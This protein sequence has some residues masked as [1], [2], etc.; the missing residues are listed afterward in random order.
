MLQDALDLLVYQ[1][2]Y[3]VLA[4]LLIHALDPLDD[5]PLRRRIGSLLQRQRPVLEQKQRTVC[6]QLSLERSVINAP[7]LPPPQRAPRPSEPPQH[8]SPRCH[9]RPWSGV[10]LHKQG[11]AP[12]ANSIGALATQLSLKATFC[13]STGALRSSARWACCRCECSSRQLARRLLNSSLK[14]TILPQ[15]R[16]AALVCALG[17]L[18][19]CCAAVRLCSGGGRHRIMDDSLRSL[20]AQMEA[21]VILHVDMDAFYCQVEQRLR[22]EL[23]GRPLAVMQYNPQN[24]TELAIEDDRRMDESDGSL[25]AVSYE[26]RAAGVKRQMRGQEARKACPELALVQVPCAH[27]KSDIS[28]YREAGAE[29]VTV[30]SRFAT[31]TERASIDEVYVDITAAALREL[32]APEP[33]RDDA[34]ALEK[35]WV[36]G[37]DDRHEMDT[38]TKAEIRNGVSGAACQAGKETQSAGGVGTWWGRAD[39]E[40]TS[41][42]RLLAAGAAVAGRMRRAVMEECGF[43]CSVR[44]CARMC[45]WG[46]A[47]CWVLLCV[48][49]HVAS[50]KGGVLRARGLAAAGRDCSLKVSGEAGKRAA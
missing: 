2:L 21:R 42:E 8:A 50:D 23:R 39:H 1:P 36:A 11:R 26:A 48:R 22:P 44:V 19:L 18:P 28:L 37:E 20:T 41:A 40:W 3:A 14:A 12:R 15:H 32:A 25:I 43:S 38:A 45:A 29:V 16:R 33:D 4:P 7:T 5:G 10:D 35:T 46:S 13:R 31:A 24:P 49:G 47:A 30:L 9:L 27:Q 6:V 17:V 34:G